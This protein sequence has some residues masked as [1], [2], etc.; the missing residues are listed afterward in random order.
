MDE[1][2]LFRLSICGVQSETLGDEYVVL[3][4][5]TVAL[6]LIGEYNLLLAEVCSWTILIQVFS[7]I[8]TLS[9]GVNATFEV[10]GDHLYSKSHSR[11]SQRHNTSVPVAI[12]VFSESFSKYEYVSISD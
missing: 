7:T 12:T 2:K 11:A 10:L 6:C 9:S 8:S 3:L 4:T 5:N 1:S